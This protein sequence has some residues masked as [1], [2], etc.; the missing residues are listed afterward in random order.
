MGNNFT[1]SHNTFSHNQ[2]SVLRQFNINK[3]HL[4]ENLHEESIAAPLTVNDHMLTNNLTPMNIKNTREMIRNA[5]FSRQF[6]MAALEERK[7][8]QL[9]VL[10]SFKKAADRIEVIM[11][12]RRIC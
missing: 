8:E 1:L 7:E 6:Y 5:T 4:V 3:Q 10:S 9:I 12:N 11:E 2:S